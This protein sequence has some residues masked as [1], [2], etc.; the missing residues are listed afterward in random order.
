MKKLITMILALALVL[1]SVAAF[2]D[3]GSNNQSFPGGAPQMGQMPGNPPSGE[4]PDFANGERPELP[5][6]VS[7]GDLPELPEG[8]TAGEKPDS[9]NGPMGGMPGDMNG[10][11]APDMIDF[12]AMASNN[13]ISAETLEKI[14]AFMEANKPAD[15]PEMNGQA[16]E[17]NGQAPEQNGQA[18]EMNGQAP[19]LGLDLLDDLL[20]NEIIT[21]EEYDALVAARTAAQTTEETAK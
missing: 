9:A 6:G 4:K 19:E 5:E 14:K 17:Q 21:Q 18:P 15:M 7:E 12:D 2:A 16:P 20:K 8:A 3:T 1:T 13:V 10:G 11:K